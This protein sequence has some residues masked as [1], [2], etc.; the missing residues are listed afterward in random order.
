[1]SNIS[2]ITVNKDKYDISF[3]SDALKR[4][5][6][7]EISYLINTIYINDRDA[8][9]NSP[10]NLA[11]RFHIY[12]D[13]INKMIDIGAKIDNNEVFDAL[14]YCDKDSQIIGPASLEPRLLFTD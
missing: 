5:N 8:H 14:E 7:N 13:I 11:L 9:N 2:S 1:M 6:Y 10:L 4:N 12:P 3:F